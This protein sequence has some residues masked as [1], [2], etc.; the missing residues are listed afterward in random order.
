MCRRRHRGAPGRRY[1]HAP[2]GADVKLADL[3]LTAVVETELRV[4]EPGSTRE[5]ED[6]PEAGSR[7]RYVGWRS[8]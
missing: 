3:N 6:L 4:T 1:D 2:Y 7:A 8:W 5:G